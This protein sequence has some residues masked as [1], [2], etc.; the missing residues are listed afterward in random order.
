MTW[1]S[2]RA[3][4]VGPTNHRDARV[5]VTDARHDIDSPPRRLVLRWD[6]DKVRD[7]DNFADAAQ[8]WLDKYIAPDFDKCKPVLKPDGYVFE[9]DYFWSC[10]MVSVDQ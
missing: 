8:A 7:A 2:I 10:D 9:G 5:I 1:S 6:R 3:R 4:Y